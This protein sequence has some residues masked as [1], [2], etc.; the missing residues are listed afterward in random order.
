M[1]TRLFE[2]SYL[3][4]KQ[5]FILKL[6]DLFAEHRLMLG[7]DH[8]YDMDL[9]ICRVDIFDFDYKQDLVEEDDVC[10]LWRLV[11]K[12]FSKREAEKILQEVKK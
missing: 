2:R 9:E 11:E 3:T 12:Y 1:F 8:P 6:L 10:E 5:W 4:K 7:S